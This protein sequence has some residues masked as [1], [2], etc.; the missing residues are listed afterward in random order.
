[1]KVETLMPMQGVLCGMLVWCTD[2]GQDTGLGCILVYTKV[3][4]H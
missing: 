3:Y 2:T 1:M 4:N